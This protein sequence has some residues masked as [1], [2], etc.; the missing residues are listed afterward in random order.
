L[1]LFL[2]WIFLLCIFSFFLN[3]FFYFL[4]FYLFISLVVF[5]LFKIV[6][7]SDME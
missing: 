1:L 6:V 4:F 5:F 3:M 7:S 2:D